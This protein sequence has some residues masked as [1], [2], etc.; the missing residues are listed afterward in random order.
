MRVLWLSH[1][2]PD[3]PTGG[4]MQRAH[5]LLRHTAARHEVHLLALHQPR[6]LPT[7]EL[8]DSVERL[9][10]SCASVL[11]FPLFAE[12]SRFHRLTTAARSLVSDD[13]YDVV[14]L[15]SAAMSAA[16]AAWQPASE[17]SVVHVDTIGLWP[18]VASWREAT[19]VLGH[20]NVE[21][22]LAMRRAIYEPNPWLSMLRRRDAEKLR[23][24]EAL[25]SHQAAMNLVV[26]SMDADRLR[27]VS[28]Y[29]R[30][31]L[32]ENGVD[33]AYFRSA[34]EEGVGLA[35]AGTLGWYPNQDAAEF[36]VTEVWP[37]LSDRRDR[38]L[39]IIG[40]DPSPVIRAVAA[41]PRVIVTGFVPDVRPYLRESSIYLCPIR[42]GGGTRLKVLDALAMA[43]PVISTEIGVE[44]LGLVEGQHYLRAE[45]AREFVSQVERLELDPALRRALGAAGRARVVERHD[46]RVVG[47]QLDIAYARALT[48]DDATVGAVA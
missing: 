10:R 41:D 29:A 32:V 12:R 8:A 18:Y 38:R 22:D 23:R 15:R 16:V 21:S 34:P 35:F 6:L 13:P 44:G 36:L 48:P 1:L 30:V 33:T 45:S 40:R 46:W 17:T 9:S 4:A 3:P 26:S 43:K 47:E 5:H 37:L 24:L 7:A 31:S 39:V 25:A 11:V 20:H 14:W 28:P 19:I 42:V 27:A 2:V